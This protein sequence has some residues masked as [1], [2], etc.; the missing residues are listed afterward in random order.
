MAKRELI[1]GRKYT[2][3]IDYDRNKLK[4]HKEDWSE[5]FRQRVLFILLDPIE[6]ILKGENKKKFDTANFTIYLGITTL[7]CCGIDAMGGFYKGEESNR[8]SGNNFKAFVRDYM[9]EIY[10]G[11]EKKVEALHDYL[12]CGLA[13]G[14][15]IKQGGIKW[16]NPYF[17]N[18]RKLGLLVNIYA[19]FKDLKN[20]F[21]EY[22]LDLK[23][24]KDIQENFKKRFNWIF[25]QGK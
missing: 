9:D 1:N 2:L 21:N 11:D 16:K 13:H 4:R 25:I 12:R 8:N 10:R 17:S 6:E 22:L 7:I 24:D 3:Y 15:C 18:N 19:L 5:W 14:F 23:N 20:A